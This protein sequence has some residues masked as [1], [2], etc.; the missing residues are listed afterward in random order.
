MYGSEPSVAL[1]AFVVVRSSVLHIGLW[2]VNHIFPIHG[3]H[4]LSGFRIE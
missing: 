2:Q 3:E 1:K 4:Y